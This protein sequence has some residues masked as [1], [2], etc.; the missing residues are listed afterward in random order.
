MFHTPAQGQAHGVPASAGPTGPGVRSRDFFEAPPSTTP[1]RLK[2]EL[3][4]LASLRFAAI[5]GLATASLAGAPLPVARLLTIFPPGGQIGAAL[6]VS[7]SGA[8]LDE[9]SELR[10]SDTNVSAKPKVSPES[11]L[12]E[13][14]KFI[15]TISSNAAPGLVEVRAVGRFGISNPRVF[16][17]GHLPEAAEKADNHAPGNA[18]EVTVGTT[19]NGRADANAVD[20]F[21][22]AAAKGQRILIECRTRAVI[23]RM[24][25]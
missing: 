3:H 24:D 23:S 9:L 17:L 1:C 2:P 7:I 20:H 18:M 6:E 13:P 22:F 16:A 15:V 5:L 21:R 4:T 10:F 19:I 8:D 14:N 25:P 11:G 12:S